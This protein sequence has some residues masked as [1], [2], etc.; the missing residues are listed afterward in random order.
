MRISMSVHDVAVTLRVYSAPCPPVSSG[1]FWPID[2]RS[3]RE[4]TQML[5]AVSR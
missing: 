1:F 2:A 5:N 3:M 4:R